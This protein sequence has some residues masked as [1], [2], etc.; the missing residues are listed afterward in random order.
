MTAPSCDVLSY[1]F[2]ALRKTPAFTFGAIVT[3]ALT[4]GAATAIFSVVYAVLLRQ[5]PY[6]NVDRVFWIWSDQPGR[7]RTPFNVPDFIDYRDSTRTLD[8]LA[9]F[10]SYGASLSDEAAGERVQGLRAT[11]NLFE[12]L[13]ARPRLGRLMQ[14]GDEQPGQDHVVVL[15]DRFWARRFGSDGSIVGRSV[16]LNGDAYVVIGVLAADFSTPVRDVEFVVPFSPDRD[17]R[18]GA[19]NS[20]NFI[21]GV[22]RLAERVSMT[23]ASNELIGIARRLQEQFP[24]ENARKR[25][26]QMVSVI[27]GVVGPFRTA[28][29]TMFAAVGAVLLIACANLANLMLTRASGRRKEIAV[30]LALGA[31]RASVARQ[32]LVE[33]LMVGLAGGTLGVL[34]AQWGVVGL[35]ALAP[36]ELPRAGEVRV[37]V[38]VLFTFP[39]RAAFLRR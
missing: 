31:S 13:G 26:V 17:Q 2:R 22:G 9:G 20:F 34:F 8:G 1:S 10:F 11:G 18:R 35:M 15:T 30:R 24:V 6:Q 36:A 7:D 32:C 23:Q 4:V 5:L 33:A 28:L 3:I 37:D 14:R 16:R 25:G 39:G 29:W 12:V 21:I 38:P 19:R 27:D